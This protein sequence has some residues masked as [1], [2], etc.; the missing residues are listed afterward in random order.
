MHH[1]S[2]LQ[3]VCGFPALKLFKNMGGICGRTECLFT[4]WLLKVQ[5]EMQLNL[6][7]HFAF[8]FFFLVL[9]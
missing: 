6:Q 2:F 1:L 5:C 7:K 9:F 8:S 4:Q 3:V